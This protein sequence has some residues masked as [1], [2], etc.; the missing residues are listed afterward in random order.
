M[1]VLVIDV[2]S[3]RGVAAFIQDGQVAYF[4]GL[5]FGL[6]NSK[7]LV[8][9]ID[10]GLKAI[11]RR[12]DQIDLIAVGIGP[13]SYTG[14]RVGSMAAKSLSFAHK[15]PLV[16]VCSLEGYT[17]DHQGAFAAIIDAKMAGC[18]LLTGER[19]GEVI[20][21]TSSPEVCAMNHVGERLEGVEVIVSPN[22]Q[23]LK[24]KIYE[25]SPDLQCKWQETAINVEHFASRA[26]QKFH[27]GKFSTDGSL[28]LLYMR[29]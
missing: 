20:S 5:P 27:E 8:P 19:E 10:E 26:V 21:Y 11:D 29:G 23:L 28:E 12:P 15:I 6:H 7:F 2:C 3:D 24:E 16:G 1:L 22:G 14:M 4:A 13:G 9:K 25:F 17:P 18:Y